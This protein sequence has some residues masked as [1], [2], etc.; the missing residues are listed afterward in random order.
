MSAAAHADSSTVP[1]PATAGVTPPG[2]AAEDLYT[3]K[4]AELRAKEI[5]NTCLRARQRH[6]NLEVWSD[7]CATQ[8]RC[9]VGSGA[10]H[11]QTKAS[12]PGVQSAQQELHLQVCMELAAAKLT[13]PGN[14][15]AGKLTA[16]VSALQ[17]RGEG[18]RAVAAT[19]RLPVVLFR[20]RAWQGAG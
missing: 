9:E 8:F 5:I 3:R 15:K 19:L 1:T 17:V 14:G 11:F 6:G 20:A 7:G 18:G 10:H 16:V 12:R 13:K 2:S 4:W